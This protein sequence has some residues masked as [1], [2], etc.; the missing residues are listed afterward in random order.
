MTDA[1]AITELSMGRDIS[2]LD[3]I[4]N[5]LANATTTAF[6]RDFPVQ[7]DFN[8]YLN[9]DGSSVLQHG[10]RGNNY[11]EITDYKTGAFK[12]TGNPLDIAI[13]GDGFLEVQTSYGMMYT[14]QGTFTLDSSGRVITSSGYVVNGVDGEIRL[15]NAN[16]FI[17]KQGRVWENDEYIGQIKMVFPQK[18]E[19]MRKL[20]NG[21]YQATGNMG[22]AV[23]DSEMQIRQGYTET[24]N[25]NTMDEMVHLMS[26]MRHFE[27]GQKLVKVYDEMLETA[28]N[29]IGDF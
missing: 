13:E 22:M 21:L 11:Q 9:V 6:K 3:L 25:V 2:R 18:I 29:K 28:M 27:L 16:P 23:K 15:R 24:S 26:T 12:Y 14:R 7:Q 19:E 5:N 1:L 20:G 4:S 10:F 8:S 17:D